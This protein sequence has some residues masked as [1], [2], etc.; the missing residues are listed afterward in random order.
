MHINGK[1]STLQKLIFEVRYQYGYA[2]LD[3]CGRIVNFITRDF[4]EWNVK[5]INLDSAALLNVRDDILL[6]FSP[7][8]FDFTLEQEAG[9]D[10]LTPD[11]LTNF[12][13]QTHLIS[14]VLIEQLGLTDFT[15]IGFR[16]FHWFACDSTNEALA[17]IGNLGFYS[18]SD[19]LE[20]AFGGQSEASSFIVI[21]PG[22][23]WK[24]RIELSAMERQLRFGIDQQ[25]LNLP[26]HLLPK[27][28]KQHLI[29]QM[30]M[31][32]KLQ[33]NPSFAAVIDADLHQEFP[34]VI[35]PRDFITT[36]YD[37][38]TKRVEAAAAFIKQEQK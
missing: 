28:Q 19:W 4:P 37:D 31:R 22:E 12:A 3:K 24:Y 29:K 26:S 27:N 8:K 9:A 32:K 23:K 20:K 10:P 25:A 7:F 16:S 35:A 11:Q 13:E 5:G 1:N 36:G 30:A 17:W 14:D 33:A 21:I 18:V 6:A 34:K 38:L 15:R 2:Y